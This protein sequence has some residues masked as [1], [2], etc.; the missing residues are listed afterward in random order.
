MWPIP[1]ALHAHDA[2]LET[3]AETG[4]IGGLAFIWLVGTY[5]WTAGWAVARARDPFWKNLVIGLGAGA[6]AYLIQNVFAVTFFILGC[7]MFFWVA[8]GLTVAAGRHTDR[9]PAV[10]T[11]SLRLKGGSRWAASAGVAVIVLVLWVEPWG[12]VRAE[13]L[14]WRGESLAEGGHTERAVEDLKQAVAINPYCQR[15]WYQLGAYLGKQGEWREALD[16]LNRSAAFSPD[17]MRTQYNLGISYRRLAEYAESERAFRRALKAERSAINY[18][19]LVETYVRWGKMDKAARQMEQALEELPYD[20][21]TQLA[22]ASFYL[23]RRDLERAELHV[24]HA[25][26]LEPTDPRVEWL[27]AQVHLA[28]G[29]GSLAREAL[30]RVVQLAPGSD[31]AGR[32]QALL[33]RLGGVE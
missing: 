13:H 3:L 20:L 23:E 18:V 31:L 8:L 29:R 5:F 11:V 1:G 2:F 21:V 12:A 7:Q 24:M 30:E 26:E 27:R 32:A 10:R 4:A 9:P 16:A 33:A 17:Y 28:A 6:L 14:Y 22:A 19:A 25:A 15:G